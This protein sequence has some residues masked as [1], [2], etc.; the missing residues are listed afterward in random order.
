MNPPA[1]E[2]LLGIIL[3]SHETKGEIFDVPEKL[4]YK[5]WHFQNLYIEKYG[6]RIHNP[7][8]ISAGPHTQLAQNIVS[9]WLCGARFIDLK[10]VHPNIIEG[11]VKPSIDIFDGA[12][13]SEKSHELSVEDA[14]DQ[15]LNAWIIIH[16]LQHK[17]FIDAHKFKAI[18]TIFNMSLGYTL[19]DIRSEKMQ[20]FIDKMM[21]CSVEKAIKLNQ[22]KQLYPKI[23]KI[24]IPDRISESFIIT[25]CRG[26]SVRELE[27]ICK[28]LIIDK[29][30]HPIIK[31]SP[32]LLGY[33]SVA[34]ILNNENSWDV[35]VS[36]D[37]FLDTIQYGEAISLIENVME[38]T[39]EIGL[40]LTVKI[41]N[42]LTCKNTTSQIPGISTEVFLSG[43]VL[44]PIAVNLAAKIQ[45][46]FEGRLD[47][48]FSGGANCFNTPNLLQS[49]FSSVSV[50]TDLLKPGGYGRLNQYF[51]E[52]SK[53]FVN[54]QAKNIR[55]FILKSGNEYG[56]Q[57]SA[58]GNLRNYAIRTLNELAY[59]KN[60]LS[61]TKFKSDRPLLHYD[62]IVAPCTQASP[63]N[64][65]TADY[66]Y[67][68]AKNNAEKAINTILA[69]NALPS[70]LGMAGDDTSRLVC[71][72]Q[73][74]DYPV[75]MK[76]IE[77]FIADLEPGKN[78]GFAKLPNHKHE[79][80]IVGGGISGLACAWYL[81][82]YGFSVDIYEAEKN[83]GGMIHK[84][85]P[86]FRISAS[87]ILKLSLNSRI[88]CLFN[89]LSV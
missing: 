7:I 70:I 58:L 60:E 66:C 61:G 52:L 21:N 26:C 46:K 20:W 51:T 76:E 73:G 18:G 38:N 29:K 6:Q 78:E 39:R 62:C 25:T 24:N 86:G 55:E 69:D 64:I 17:L 15:F 44:H 89:F 77:R 47:I 1:L 87:A 75:L 48:S 28:F 14:Y 8:G 80:A 3:K 41:S 68:T 4:F 53:L 88:K 22:I 74:Y 31:L 85:V 32:T 35:E 11:R 84:M 30:L 36:E 49:G 16:I 57:E 67:F 27:Y 5:H 83:A 10:T 79:V 19:A 50:C 82:M 40:D 54:Y 23:D 63:L 34:A 81:T 2:Q 9:G 71:T 65:R 37:D 43:K 59:Q 13:N 33:K 42:S 56:V 72:R 12:F 45:S